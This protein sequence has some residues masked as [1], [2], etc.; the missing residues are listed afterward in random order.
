MGRLLAQMGDRPPVAVELITGLRV[1]ARDF[2]QDRSRAA[3]TPPAKSLAGAQDRQRRVCMRAKSLDLPIAD[4][5]IAC[6]PAREAANCARSGTR[7]ASATFRQFLMRV[8]RRGSVRAINPHVACVWS[9]ERPPEV[10]VRDG[11]REMKAGR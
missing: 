9:D 8:E 5:L 7:D 4:R 1:F 6:S 10:G 3:A 11:R 2:F